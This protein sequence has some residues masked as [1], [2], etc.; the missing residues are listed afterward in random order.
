MHNNNVITEVR[1]IYLD[2]PKNIIASRLSIQPE[3]CSRIL[4]RLKKQGFIR[5]EGYPG[6]A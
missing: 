3:T 4:A 1:E 6:F 5:V 2:A